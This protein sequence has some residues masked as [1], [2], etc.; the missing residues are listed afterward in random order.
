[1][2]PPTTPPIRA[3]LLLLDRFE[4]P[5]VGAAVYVTTGVTT[6]VMTTRDVLAPETTSEVVTR[7]LAGAVEVVTTEEVVLVVEVVEVVLLVDEVV[8]VEVEDAVDDVEEDVEEVEEEDA[9]GVS[10]RRSIRH[11]T[12]MVG[13]RRRQTY[14]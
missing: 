1:M 8:D 3:P 10:K 5:R 13:R 11:E 12:T 6:D 9:A 4:E 2:T 14:K 7:V